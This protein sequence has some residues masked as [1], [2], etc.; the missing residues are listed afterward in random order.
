MVSSAAGPKGDDS[1]LYN[2][3][4]LAGAERH[5]LNDLVRI[6][7]C[8]AADFSEALL[9]ASN[10]SFL[11][12]S[13]TTPPTLASW[14]GSGAHVLC[15]AEAAM[16]LLV[17]WSAGRP[18]APAPAVGSSA[19]QMSASSSHAAT[20]SRVSLSSNR[21]LQQQAGHFKIDIL[22][23]CTRTTHHTQ[24][25]TA[26]LGRPPSSRWASSVHR[27]NKCDLGISVYQ[28]T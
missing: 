6:A 9:W 19:W 4:R 11:K 26:G 22:D 23:L 17:P 8:D 18:P 1:V 12:L 25:G 16:F 20:E 28:S 5:A 7:S 2:P 13:L 24:L 14:P 21:Q 15:L 10:G 3:K 27:N